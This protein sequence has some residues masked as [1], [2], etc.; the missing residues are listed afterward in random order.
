M[1]RIVVVFHAMETL[2]DWVQAKP[3]TILSVGGVTSYSKWHPPPSST[4]KC[5]CDAATFSATGEYGM[6][7][8]LRDELGDLVAYRML[9]LAG[10]PAINQLKQVTSSI[11]L[12]PRPDIEQQIPKSHPEKQDSP[13]SGS[14]GRCS[15]C[16]IL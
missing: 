14:G 4:L 5:N 2:Y 16:S 8:I 1:V 7:I 12:V 9:K 11:V 10:L 3:A 13:P 15:C 6:G